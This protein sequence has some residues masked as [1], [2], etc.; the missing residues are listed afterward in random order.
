M[1]LVTSSVQQ[2]GSWGSLITQSPHQKASIVTPWRQQEAWHQMM[3][4]KRKTKPACYATTITYIQMP[5]RN[6]SLSFLM[7]RGEGCYMLT[8]ER[9]CNTGTFYTVVV[10]SIIDSF[11]FFLIKINE[12]VFVCRCHCFSAILHCFQLLCWGAL[13]KTQHGNVDISPSCLCFQIYYL[14]CTCKSIA[15]AINTRLTQPVLAEE[16]QAHQ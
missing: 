7:Y 14:Q 13:G 1:P 15:C 11:F 12:Q 2:A 5:Y 10:I 8:S 16:P 3:W 9:R 4:D 6:F